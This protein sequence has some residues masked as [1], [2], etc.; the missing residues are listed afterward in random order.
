MGSHIS[1]RHALLDDED[2]FDDELLCHAV[3]A[4]MNYIGGF[5][6]RREVSVEGLR[7]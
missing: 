5:F 1:W 6:S 4:R 3:A 2:D 7:I